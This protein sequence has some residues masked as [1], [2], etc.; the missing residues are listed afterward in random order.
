MT[1][2]AGWSL[3]FNAARRLGGLLSVCIV[4]V[5]IGAAPVRAAT[6][7]PT[8]DVNSMAS[9]T[10]YTGAQAWWSAGYT[11]AGVDVAI[12]DSGV[13]PVQAERGKGRPGPD[14]SL[15][16]QSPGP[17]QPHTFGHGTGGPA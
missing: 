5:S 6:Y 13:S 14:L 17:H 1:P 8:S 11:G 3:E 15:E 2:N 7:D 10:A 16:S 12:I 9:T 4:L